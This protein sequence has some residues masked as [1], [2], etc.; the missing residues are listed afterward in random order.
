[1]IDSNRIQNGN[2][3]AV[4][5]NGTAKLVVVGQYIRERLETADG[6]KNLATE[7]YRCPKAGLRK[8]ECDA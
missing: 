5:A 1:V 8:S 3:I 7:R 4:R 6:C 2:T